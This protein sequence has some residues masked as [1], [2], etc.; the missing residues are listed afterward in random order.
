MSIMFEVYYKAPPDPRKEAELT[1]QISRL[2]GHLT[3]RENP[4]EYGSASVCLT[5]EFD[6]LSLAEIAAK[7]LRQQGEHVEGPVDYG[8]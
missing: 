7:L 2:G 1:V 5:Y 6:D 4:D 3:F 8:P